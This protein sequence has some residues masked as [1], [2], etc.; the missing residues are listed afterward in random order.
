MPWFQGIAD[1]QS[2]AHSAAYEKNLANL[3]R[4]VR[5]D[6]KAPALPVVVTAVGFGDGKVHD[7]QMAVGDPVKYPEFAGNVKSIDTR[8]FV[9][10][11]KGQASCYY[12]NAET[13]LEIGE[14]MGRAMLE[15]MK[16]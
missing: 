4:D 10:S 2:S 1:C 3:I 11:S 13:F 9:R 6:R 5:R 15:L 14:A 7:A 12:E 8:P 16:K